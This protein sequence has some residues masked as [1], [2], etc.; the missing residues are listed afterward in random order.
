MAPLAI[1]AASAV[2]SASTVSVRYVGSGEV[3]PALL[4]GAGPT[5]RADLAFSKLRPSL[6]H[7]TCETKPPCLTVSG[8]RD[9][10]VSHHHIT[11]SSP[12]ASYCSS[13]G[14]CLYSSSHESLRWVQAT[15][16]SLT[17]RA[18]QSGVVCWALSLQIAPRLVT[19]LL[20][21]G[22]CCSPMARAP[23]TFLT[24]LLTFKAPVLKAWA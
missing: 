14:V 11:I 23:V 12:S 16:S 17:G 4:A 13:Q 2:T 15:A 19:V 7:L 10:A 21:S 5:S 6:C 3:L 18:W 22:A 8:N 24:L 9:A 20:I 1:K